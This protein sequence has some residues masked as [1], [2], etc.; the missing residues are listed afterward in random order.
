VQE[1]IDGM[2]YQQEE[3]ANA[4]RS[5]ESLRLWR[6]FFLGLRIA[7]R[8]NAMEIDGEKG[9]SMDVDVQQEIDREDKQMVEEEMAGGFFPDEADFAQPPRVERAYEPPQQDYGGGGFMADDDEDEGGGF[10]PED[11]ADDD[12]VKA[13]IGMNREHSFE[14]SI[15]DSHQ[16]RPRRRS[17]FADDFVLEEDE[18]EEESADSTHANSDTGPLNNDENAETYIAQ[19]GAAVDGGGGFLPEDTDADVNMVDQPP[20]EA[21]PVLRD[22]GTEDAEMPPESSPSDT[23]SLPLEDPEDEDAD[24][25]WLVDAT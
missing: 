21:S 15:L 2:I 8:V 24:P 13:P 17:S 12:A 10:I 22:A 16:L 1:V 18:D 25:D 4:A 11:D 14:S 23:G 9:P 6:R 20:Q 3:A 19:D 5:R 7:Q